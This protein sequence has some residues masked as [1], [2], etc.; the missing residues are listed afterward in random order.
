MYPTNPNY[1]IQDRKYRRIGIA[2]IAALVIGGA[3]SAYGM[4]RDTPAPVPT[5]GGGALA[6]TGAVI[7]RHVGKR[8]DEL[9][10][11]HRSPQVPMSR[12][13]K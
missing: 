9:Y 2:G 6:V 1:E 3:I 12:W 4:T 5:L 8:R 7:G 13:D 10:D 11:T